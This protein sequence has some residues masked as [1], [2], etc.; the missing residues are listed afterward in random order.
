MYLQ[1]KVRLPK[2]EEIK[3]LVKLFYQTISVVYQLTKWNQKYK[4]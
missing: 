1:I 2:S 4:Q 3:S